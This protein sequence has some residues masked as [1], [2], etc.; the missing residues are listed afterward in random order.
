MTTQVLVKRE[1]ILDGLNC[2]HCAEVINEKVNNLEEVES[3]NLNFINK[4]LTLNIKPSYN[5]EKV[6]EKV[7]KIIDDTEPGLNIKVKEIKNKSKKKE[8]VLNGLNCAHCAEVICEKVDKL[9]EVESANLNF[10]NKVLTINLESGVNSK[11]TLNKII[12]I[13]NDT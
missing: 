12:K 4:I 9:S 8:L 13:I 2:A 3:A 11:D 7:I 5:Q 10:I 1:I 6:I